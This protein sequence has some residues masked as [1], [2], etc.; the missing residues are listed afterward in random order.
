MLS[1]ERVKRIALE[2]VAETGLINLSRRSLCERAGVAPGS[3]PYVMG[4]TFAEFVNELRLETN[5]EKMY[6]VFKS[7]VNPALRRE[8]I[9]N[10]AIECAERVGYLE[11]TRLDVARA[12]GISTALIT[13]YYSSMTLLRDA[14]M[15][16]AVLR[17]IPTIIAQGLTHGDARA[18]EAPDA[19]KKAAAASLLSTR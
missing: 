17:E 9:L 5:A 3:F 15:Q 13:R 7:R 10:V 16:A 1:K 4:C 8:H 18:R 14:V 12:A 2:M 19:L 11:F 6:P